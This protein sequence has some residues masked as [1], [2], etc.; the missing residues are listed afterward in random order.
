MGTFGVLVCKGCFYTVLQYCSDLPKLCSL[1]PTGLES[2]N[3]FLFLLIF[4]PDF[5]SFYLLLSV[6]LS[7]YNVIQVGNF[8]LSYLHCDFSCYHGLLST[9]LRSLPQELYFGIK[10]VSLCCF[11]LF[12]QVF[13][14][15]LLLLPCCLCVS[16]KYL[17]AELH[18]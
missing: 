17:I 11:C 14:P 7:Q 5:L 9:L 13:L 8:L 3:R 18:F 16:C 1:L 2:P 4:Y 10:I 15:F 6:C 12:P